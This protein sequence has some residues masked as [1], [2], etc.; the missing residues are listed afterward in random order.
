V[1][2]LM[3]AHWHAHT[4]GGVAHIA[5][6]VARIIRRCSVVVG[7]GSVFGIFTV[8]DVKTLRL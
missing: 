4:Y 5:R 8:N 1:Y 2:Y 3:H 6:S 7:L